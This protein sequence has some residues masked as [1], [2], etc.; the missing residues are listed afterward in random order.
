MRHAKKT[1][2]W[3]VR[4][5]DV[6]CCCFAAVQPLRRCCF[7]AAAAANDAAAAAAAAASRG[8]L[9]FCRHLPNLVAL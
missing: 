6:G 8:V 9:T 2:C 5:S 7:A 3:R 1:V 4:S